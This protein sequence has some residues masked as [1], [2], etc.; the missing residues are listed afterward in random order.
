MS[1][2][3]EDMIASL[4]KHKTWKD[5]ALFLNQEMSIKN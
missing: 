3:L 2:L 1:I 4:T 5:V